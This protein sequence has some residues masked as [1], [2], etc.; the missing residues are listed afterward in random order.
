MELSSED[1]LRLNVL[2]A[3]HVKAIRINESTMVVHGLTDQGEAKVPLNPTCRDDQY[4]KYVREL[5]SGYATGST[6]GYPVYLKRW[7]RMGQA[8]E[9]NLGQLL[10]LGEV[11]ALLAVVSSPSITDELA[12]RAWWVDSASDHARQMLKAQAVVEGEMGPVLVEHL[13]EHL[14]FE[15]EPA[16]MVET[17]RLLLDTGLLS[18]E[19][20]QKIWQKAKQKNVYFLGFLIAT[21]DDFPEMQ[22]AHPQY[23]VLQQ[24]LTPLCDAGNVYAKL[25]LRLLGS[26][27]QTYLTTC[28]SVFKRPGDQDVVN[29]LINTIRHYFSSVQLDD[30]QVENEGEINNIVESVQSQIDA[31]N[32]PQITQ[33]LSVVPEL[34]IHLESIMLFSRLGYSVLRPIFLNTTAIGSLMRKKLTPV[35]DVV[36]QHIKRVKAPI[37]FS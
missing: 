13:V 12:S 35:T 15:T 3:N 22:S 16:M 7:S 26:A 36:L 27:G 31:S 23:E 1:M 5:F 8:N 9:D 11:D 28:E 29:D 18:S 4:L 33:V 14:A 20:R 21:P 32:D 10:L 25:C 34:R 2:M 30:Y 17:V 19:S 6:G 37:A 24:K